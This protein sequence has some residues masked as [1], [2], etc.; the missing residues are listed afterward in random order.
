MKVYKIEHEPNWKEIEISGQQLTHPLSMGEYAEYYSKWVP[1]DDI[2]FEKLLDIVF[3]VKMGIG[4]QE[5]DGDN[6]ILYTQRI[7]NKIKKGIDRKK[8]LES[9][10]VQVIAYHTN[11][12]FRGSEVENKYGGYYK[13][14]EQKIKGNRSAAVKVY[15]SLIY[16][17]SR[18]GTKTTQLA[19]LLIEYVNQCDEMLTSNEVIIEPLEIKYYKLTPLKTKDKIRE[20]LKKIIKEFDIEIDSNSFN[21]AIESM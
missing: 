5:T 13:N 16:E 21:M 18:D 4:F 8:A 10:V 7:F 14:P 20:C 15:E 1:K 2:S 6:I 9:F 17:G 3:S 11:K 19:N 12:M